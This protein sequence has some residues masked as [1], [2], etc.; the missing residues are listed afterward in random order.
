MEKG[1]S[2]AVAAVGNLGKKHTLDGVVGDN[3]DANFP[4]SKKTHF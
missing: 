1:V 3:E 2:V 4:D